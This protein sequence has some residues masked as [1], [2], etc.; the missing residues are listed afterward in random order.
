MKM[1]WNLTKIWD[2]VKYLEGKIKW[3]ISVDINNKYYRWVDESKN[4]LFL[5]AV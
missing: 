4:L 2:K 3:F 1:L 5:K